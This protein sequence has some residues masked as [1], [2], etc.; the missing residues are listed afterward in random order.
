MAYIF[1]IIAYKKKDYIKEF[2]GYLESN[3]NEYRINYFLDSDKLKEKIIVPIGKI[4]D[5]I[6]SPENTEYTNIGEYKQ[7][8]KSKILYGNSNKAVN[9]MF[10]K[11][12]FSLK[13]EDKKYSSSKYYLGLFVVLA[14]IMY[15]NNNFITYNFYH[16]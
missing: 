1:E 12:W 6:F 16:C 8:F 15:D 3:N 4:V 5:K 9:E 2:N 10:V 7:N 13:S 14:I 11:W